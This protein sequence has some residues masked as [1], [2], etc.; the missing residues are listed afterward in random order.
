MITRITQ[1]LDVLFDRIQLLVRGLFRY[2]SLRLLVTL[3]TIS[4]HFPVS[5]S[6]SS[7]DKVSCNSV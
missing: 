4:H 2:G 5:Q 1:H 3:V 7:T 6:H